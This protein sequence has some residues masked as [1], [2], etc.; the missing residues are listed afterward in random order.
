MESLTGFGFIRADSMMKKR[1]SNN[2][3]PRSNVWLAFD[4]S[5][6]AIPSPSNSRRH[7]PDESGCGETSFRR[8]EFYLNS[9]SPAGL[10]APAA[11]SKKATRDDKAFQ[12]FNGYSGGV[13][14]RDC[15]LSERPNEGALGSAKW[16]R[17]SKIYEGFDIK[18]GALDGNR[19]SGE[20]FGT[21]HLEAAHGTSENK[22]RKVK[23]K[24]GGVTRTI[25]AKPDTMS[26]D[27]R[28][29]AKLPRSLDASYPQLSPQ[30][31]YVTHSTSKLLL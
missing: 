26:V 23:L 15:R 5:K 1:R 25:H 28:S 2:R 29:A 17:T 12:K 7:S 19:K 16:K 14:S 3:R 20:D 9:P 4:A 18:S 24:V 27:A 8:K 10:A 11:H 22:L 13:S 30:V 21:H 31:Y 6:L